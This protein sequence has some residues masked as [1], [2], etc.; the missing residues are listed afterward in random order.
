MCHRLAGTLFTGRPQAE[1][2]WPRQRTL[3]G[4]EAEEPSAIFHAG[5]NRASLKKV[6][7]PANNQLKLFY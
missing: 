7:L 2:A 1:R 3:A 5:K 6:S 4:S